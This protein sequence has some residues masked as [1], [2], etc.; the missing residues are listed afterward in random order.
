LRDIGKPM[1]ISEF[2]FVDELPENL[3]SSL[4]TIDEIEEELTKWDNPEK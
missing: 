1:G 3:K 4:P 2:S